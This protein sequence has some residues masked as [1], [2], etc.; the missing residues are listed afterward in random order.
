MGVSFAVKRSASRHYR[1]DANWAS[2]E[3]PTRKMG[4]D[5]VGEWSQ[6]DD[7]GCRKSKFQGRGG[8]LGPKMLVREAQ[9]EGKIR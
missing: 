2:G 1:T 8:E 5:S 6:N 3:M 4:W 9:G 7:W